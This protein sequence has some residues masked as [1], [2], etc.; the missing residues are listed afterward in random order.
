VSTR[1]RQFIE[2]CEGFRARPG[3]APHLSHL[4]RLFPDAQASLRAFDEG[5]YCYD[6][7]EGNWWTGEA[8]IPRAY[9]ERRWSRLFTPLD[10]VDDP[11]RCEQ[12]VIV[13]RR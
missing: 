10:Y 3:L 2:V 6:A 1:N 13:V 4:P 11:A 9:V 5:R 7:L 8:C 12:N